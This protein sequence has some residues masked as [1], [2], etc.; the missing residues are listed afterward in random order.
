MG[1]A[2]DQRDRTRKNSGA[3][4][5]EVG[6]KYKT[7]AGYGVYFNLKWQ[8]EESRGPVNKQKRMENIGPALHH[9]YFLSCPSGLQQ[10]AASLT[11]SSKMTIG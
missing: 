9:C 11:I 7:K 5:I 3:G 8:T 4:S 1:F 6:K 10:G 2:V